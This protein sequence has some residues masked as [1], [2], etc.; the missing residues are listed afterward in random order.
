MKTG[1]KFKMLGIPNYAIPDVTKGNIYVATSVYKHNVLFIDDVGDSSMFNL[2]SFEYEIVES[3]EEHDPV[4]TPSHYL[5]G[6]METIEVIEA[7]GLG[8]CLGNAVKY[9]TRAGKK[10]KDK[11]VQDLNKAIWYINRKI[12]Q[13]EGSDND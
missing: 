10:D 9:I 11:E 5:Q 6:N 2:D 7:F 3:S 1:D 13:L 4:N 12:T 8:Y